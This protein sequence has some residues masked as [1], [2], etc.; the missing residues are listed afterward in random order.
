MKHL[1][2]YNLLIL[3]LVCSSCG[4]EKKAQS[5]E[6]DLGST[7]SGLFGSSTKEQDLKNKQDAQMKKMKEYNDN[8]QEGR[9]DSYRKSTNGE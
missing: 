7:I 9:L 1:L 3:S 4:S 6:K 5:S 2:T 8:M